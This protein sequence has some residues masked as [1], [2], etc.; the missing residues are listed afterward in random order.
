[1]CAYY[2]FSNNEAPFFGGDTTQYLE[3][4]QDIEDFRIDKIHYRSI[5]FPILL[6]STGSAHI[7][8]KLF[9]LLSLILYF[10]CLYIIA[11]YFLKL[12]FKFTL[13]FLMTIVLTLPLFVQNSTVVMSENFTT[14][15][16][17]LGFV[18]FVK[19]FFK[20]DNLYL[21]LSGLFWGF[22]SLIRPTFQL[23]IFPVLLTVFFYLYLSE[24]GKFY[25]T[26]KNTFN[27][28]ILFIMGF[29]FLIFLNCS[30]NSIL[31]NYFGLTP[32][33]GIT[34]ST[35]TVNFVEELP[36]N[37]KKE[38]EILVKHRDRSLI[39]GKS[40]TGL[41]FIEDA[42]PELMDS[43]GLDFVQLSKHMGKLNLI[44]IKN[45]PIKYLRMVGISGVTYWFPFATELVAHNRI[46]E[47]LNILV[48]TITVTLF[49]LQSIFILVLIISTL[50]SL[51]L[52][53]DYLQLFLHS[54]REY[55]FALIVLNV[56]I[57]YNFIITILLSVGEPRHRSPTDIFIVMSIFFV[58]GIYLKYKI[59]LKNKKQLIK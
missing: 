42:I 34:L 58:I 36:D 25:L 20:K 32:L 55:I 13:I 33:L 30:I 18:F 57:F 2:Y 5:G 52:V 23:L 9:F 21:I 37:Y 43:T 12:K 41:V 47:Y 7:P 26:L 29:A 54:H 24:R 15:T 16:L 8:S 17:L 48:W 19:G 45:A 27:R 59:F 53:N 38:R 40:H 28:S 46:I 56:I 6:V 3:V 50:F 49:F 31:F 11:L 4:A 22:T 51:P 14:F 44:L 35:R 1:M 39:R 10:V